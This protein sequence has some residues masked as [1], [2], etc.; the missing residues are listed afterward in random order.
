M[1][2][3]LALLVFSCAKK[4][5]P[6]IIKNEEIVP[7][8]FDSETAV[9]TIQTTSTDSLSSVVDQVFLNTQD[10]FDWKNFWNTLNWQGH[11]KNDGEGKELARLLDL[12]RHSCKS[13]D[14]QAFV[15]FFNKASLDYQKT[16]KAELVEKIYDHYIWCG[17]VIPDSVL[18]QGLELQNEAKRKDLAYLEKYMRLNPA[19]SAEQLQKISDNFIK[20]ISIEQKVPTYQLLKGVKDYSR[21]TPAVFADTDTSLILNNQ[22][23]VNLETGDFIDIAAAFRWEVV[24][25]SHE[26]T[27]RLFGVYQS[28]HQKTLLPFERANLLRSQWELIKSAEAA[29]Q[30]GLEL[31]GLLESFASELFKSFGA[32]ESYLPISS[33]LYRFG[34]E[35]K[36]NK[37]D[38][39][40][41]THSALEEL[42][43]LRGNLQVEEN[44][45]KANES[46]ARFCKTLSGIGVTTKSINNT[47]ELKALGCYKYRGSANLTINNSLMMGIFSAIITNGQSI[48]VTHPQAT[49]SLVNLTQKKKDADIDEVET[50]KKYNTL[51]IP[52]I[53]GIKPLKDTPKF[54]AGATYYMSLY[55]LYRDGRD[56]TPG[57]EGVAK[58]EKGYA[59]GNLTL[60][61]QQRNHPHLKFISQGGIGQI[62]APSKV[63]GLGVDFSYEEYKVKKWVRS[64]AGNN[65]FYLSDSRKT[66]RNLEELAAA[67]TNDE[68]FINVY[69]DPEYLDVIE[70]EMKEVILSGVEEIIESEGLMDVDTVSVLEILARRSVRKALE[71]ASSAAYGDKLTDLMPE[72]AT[73]LVIEQGPI[74]LTYDNGEQGEN[75]EILYR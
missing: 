52:L 35:M 4:E 5:S 11:S 27:K 7:T 3:A 60:M 2:S 24:N 38:Q 32:V 57:L 47:S 39:G 69:I 45:T 53:V 17:T 15:G 68:N 62:A 25:K 65:N 6:V 16:V 40:N 64:F 54:K 23:L 43:L 36:G 28:H 34:A 56:L 1:I 72:L 9:S 50:E 29:G 55:H 31:L 63:G 18:Y 46:L 22:A 61:A 33:L 14:S 75:G 13:S 67:A 66:K 42:L 59:G 37:M 48:E 44:L 20:D 41:D 51:A 21:L 71:T 26:N 74:G 58:P 8:R 70:P 19:P 30:N 73:E 12:G 10:G 49:L